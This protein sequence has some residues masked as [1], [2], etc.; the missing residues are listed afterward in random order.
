MLYHFTRI[1]NVYV[2]NKNTLQNTLQY[3]SARN[4][5]EKN[6]TEYCGEFVLNYDKLM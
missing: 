2:Y 4:L 5:F 6:T 3:V 1:I